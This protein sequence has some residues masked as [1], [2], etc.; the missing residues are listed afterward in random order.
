VR[1]TAANNPEKSANRPPDAVGGGVTR[2]AP[3]PT[4]A[5]HLGNVRTFVVNWALARRLGWRVVLRIEDLDTPR[6]KPGAIEDT[7]ATLAWLGVDWDSGPTVQS[8][9]LEPYRAAMRELAARGLVYPCELTRGEI[10]AAAS[11]PHR[12]DA[13][14]ELDGFGVGG[15]S[16]YPAG[17]R[18][19]ER[20]SA[21]DRED[22]NW[23]FAVEPGVVGFD[24]LVRGPQAIDVAAEVGDFVVWTKRGQ[25]AYQLAVVVD[26]ARAGVNR[27]VRG[28]DLVGSAGRQ[29][30]LYRALNLRP[31]PVYWHVPLVVGA[32]GRRL[33]K[34]H[35]DTRV[36][37]YR[38]AGVPAERVIGLMAFWCGVTGERTAMDASAFSAAFDSDRLRRTDV[39]FT[40]VDDAW[41]H[42][43]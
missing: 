42:S 25:P 4:G 39:V 9:D 37:S 1:S 17:L 12:A 10:E 18:P 24:D 22:V 3:S 28:N 34:R 40:E 32:D 2:L 5:L 33:A 30:L 15:E 27:V 11:A 31:E 35:G 29:L 16:R 8:E 21:F 13:G 41:L 19:A 26:D 20:P 43:G 14:G 38:E 23:R 6:V 36:S 7:I